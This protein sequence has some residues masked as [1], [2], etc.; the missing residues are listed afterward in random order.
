MEI[1]VKLLSFAQRR[2]PYARPHSPARQMASIANAASRLGSEAK[3]Y[4]SPRRTGPITPL[5]N[6]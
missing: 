5:G 1:E 2:F 6:A 4:R 3:P